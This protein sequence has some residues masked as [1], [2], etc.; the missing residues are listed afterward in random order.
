LR[1]EWAGIHRG[2]I[3]ELPRLLAKEYD[4]LDRHKP[5][6]EFLKEHL[7]RMLNERTSKTKKKESV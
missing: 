6:P 5:L 1:K 4:E 7:K 2:D 3:M